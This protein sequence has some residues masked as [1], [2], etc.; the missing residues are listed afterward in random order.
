MRIDAHEISLMY[1]NSSGPPAIAINQLSL[2]FQTDNLLGVL[3]PSGSGKSSLLYVLSGLKQPS[4][5]TVFIDDQ[6]LSDLPEE[7]KEQ[8]RLTHFG[9]I[10]QRHYLLPHLSIRENI[11]LPLAKQD[12]QDGEKAAELADRLGLAVN[13][14]LFPNELSVGQRQL[15]AI[16]RAL[17][18]DPSVIFADEPTAS[19]DSEAGLHVMDY[20]AERQA[21]T[22]IIVVTHDFRIL[23][24]ATEIIQLRDGRV[25]TG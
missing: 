9:F 13:L 20:L 24:Q 5:G 21:R 8:L 19:L 15:V 1:Q 22:A 7:K 12:C 2:T 23:R 6:D 4:S 3:G 25:V 14:A 16:A 18:N 17:I 10:F 11:L